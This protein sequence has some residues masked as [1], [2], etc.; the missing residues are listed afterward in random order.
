MDKY[1]FLRPLLDPEVLIAGELFLR[2]SCCLEVLFCKVHNT[3]DHVANNAHKN[4]KD[5]SHYYSASMMM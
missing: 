4:D 2:F 5:T 3:E 1:T